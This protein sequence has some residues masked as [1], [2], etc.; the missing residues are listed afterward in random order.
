ME[1]AIQ[2]AKEALE[3]HEEI[4]VLYW[5]A[6]MRLADFFILVPVENSEKK[7][8]VKLSGIEYGEWEDQQKV[9]TAKTILNEIH[10]VRVD[11]DEIRIRFG[12][13]K[14]WQ[15]LHK[16]DGKPVRIDTLD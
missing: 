7:F 13:G 5:G 16:W 8:A 3:T 10:E 6:T 11:G 4:Y 15:N 12:W 9:P 14:K 1:A 2:K